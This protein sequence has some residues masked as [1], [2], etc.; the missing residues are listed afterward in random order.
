MIFCARATR[1][2]RRPSLD[3]CSGDHTS[4]LAENAG[5]GEELSSALAWPVSR[6]SPWLLSYE[7]PRHLIAIRYRLFVPPSALYCSG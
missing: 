6:H 1:G 3:A 2:L 5:A 4:R 7:A